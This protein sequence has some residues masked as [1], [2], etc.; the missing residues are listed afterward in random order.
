LRA[1]WERAGKPEAGRVFPVRIGKRAGQEKKTNSHAKRL[2]SAL[3][4]AGVFRLKPAEVPETGKGR[5]T[6]LGK[7]A[8][9]T[10]LA[11]DP[12]DPLYFETE[13]SLPVDFHSF[14]RAFNTALAE[15]G[16][17]LQH[18]MHL[19]AHADP[20]THMRYVMKTTAMRTIPDAALPRLPAGRLVETI[21]R[22][23]SRRAR[24]D[25]H[26]SEVVATTGIVAARDDST[27]TRQ[28]V[29]KCV[30]ATVR[31]P[32]GISAPT[33]GLEPATRRLTAACSTN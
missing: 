25:S 33:A 11:P 27:E 18:A 23:D 10:K 22:D 1:W 26:P 29:A 12:R 13:V 15:A 7:E 31:L 30:R 16:V 28:R 5:R 24:D 2:R 20:K 21:G 32:A 9:G 14:R 4:R 19:A 6:D 8:T 17:N 3:M